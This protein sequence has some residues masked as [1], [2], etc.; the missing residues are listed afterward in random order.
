MFNTR[1]ILRV[2]AIKSNR[3]KDAI[4]K[5]AIELLTKSERPE[6]ITSRQIAA[7]ANANLAMINY[8]FG[9]KDMLM[10][11]AVSR[12]MDISAQIFHSPA[13]ASESPKERLRNIL[14]N[15]CE[16][17]VKYQRYTK[18]YVPHLL[19]DDEI[20]LPQYL[21]PQIRDHFG[22]KKGEIECRIIAYEMVSFLQLAFYRSD[23]L[24]R[25]TGKDWSTERAVKGLINWELEQFMPSEER[26]AQ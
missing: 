16:I 25:Y 11:Q 2:M 8:Y 21:L 3:Q 15:I 1:L 18:L 20:T 23:A 17:V 7:H 14:M 22:N 12:I 5:A 24:A 9:S 13:N 6:E 26:K 4:L 10:S 19:L